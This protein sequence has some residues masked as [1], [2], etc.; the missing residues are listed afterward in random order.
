MTFG[1]HLIIDANECKGDITNKEH[2]KNFINDL[3]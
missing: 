1:K 3:I 2:I